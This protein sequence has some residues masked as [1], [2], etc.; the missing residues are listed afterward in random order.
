MKRRY[1][2]SEQVNGVGLAENEP[3]ELHPSGEAPTEA[4]YV[5]PAS[6]AQQ[7]LWFL[8]RFSPGDTAYLIPWSLRLT[9]PLDSSALEK[10]LDEIVRRHEV[11]RTGTFDLE[12]GEP[13]VQVVQASQKASPVPRLVSLDCV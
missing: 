11:L 6:F 1:M 2:R 13:P 7:R 12:N 5:F 10:S 8:D 9:G 3:S 4:G